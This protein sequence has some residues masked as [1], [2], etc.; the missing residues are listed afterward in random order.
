[1]PDQCRRAPPGESSSGGKW[2]CTHGETDNVTGVRRW[3]DGGAWRMHAKA[4]LGECPRRTRMGC[5]IDRRKID[6]DHFNSSAAFK[7][8]RQSSR[9]GKLRPGNPFNRS[10]LGRRNN[11]SRCR[12]FGD[13]APKPLGRARAQRAGASSVAP[14]KAG[15]AWFLT[16]PPLSRVA[17][18]HGYKVTVQTRPRGVNPSSCVRGRWRATV[19]PRRSRHEPSPAWPSRRGACRAR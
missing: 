12:R 1:M 11:W 14:G 7:R 2:E 13:H 6:R 18:T 10:Q 17:H 5:P 8:P 9:R 15:R 4:R 16:G 19:G 3:R